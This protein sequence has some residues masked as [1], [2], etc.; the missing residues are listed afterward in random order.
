MNRLNIKYWYWPDGKKRTEEWTFDGKT[1]RVDGP[2]IIQYYSTGNKRE[3]YWYLN[4]QL[5]RIDSPA[6]ILYYSS[7]KIKREFWY[8][9]GEKANHK[10]WLIEH[11]LIEK[12]Y[13]TW[14][15]EEKV[16][17]RLSWM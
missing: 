1:H 16:L 4:N 17:W 14:T 2:V 13:N 5:H 10:E 12:P 11:D 7:G 9:I 8:L 15:D 6:M 3:E